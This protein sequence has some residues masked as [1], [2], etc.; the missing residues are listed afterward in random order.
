MQSSPTNI[1]NTQ[2]RYCGNESSQQCNFDTTDI[3]PQNVIYT[4]P[5]FK[6][7]HFRDITNQNL[8]QSTTPGAIGMIPCNDAYFGDPNNSVQKSCY[9]R[10]KP[11]GYAIFN[12][13][14]Y[15]AISAGSTEPNMSRPWLKCSNDGGICSVSTPTDI[16]YGSSGTF[17]SGYV[18][19]GASVPCSTQTFG[20]V[21]IPTG[22]RA[23][24]V[25]PGTLIGLG[26]TQPSTSVPTFSPVPPYTPTPYTPTPYT[27]AP[28]TPPPYNLNAPPKVTNG[29]PQTAMQ[30]VTQGV[31]SAEFYGW[32]G[33]DIGGNNMGYYSFT[34]EADCANKCATT[35]N[36][37]YY[38]YIPGN[39]YLKSVRPSGDGQTT[40]KFF[41]GPLN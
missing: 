41:F 9:T 24:Y 12:G 34:N 36:C 30:R 38:S 7:S 22:G 39:C 33:I 40:A 4:D 2:F 13:L 37:N 21:N 3:F 19:A 20:N 6:Y 17:V 32:P 26:Q 16:L 23:C 11:M 14:P 25:Q 15:A 28:Y 35:A 18:P 5:T 10:P 27:P 1:P 29:T 8:Q 31:N